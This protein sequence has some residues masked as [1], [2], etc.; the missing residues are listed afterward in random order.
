M[1]LVE[2]FVRRD[3]LTEIRTE[4]CEY[5]V[6]ILKM[7][8]GEDMV[9]EGAKRYLPPSVDAQGNPLPFDIGKAWGELDMKYN[10]AARE[11]RDSM[12]GHPAR[13]VYGSLQRF[14]AEVKRML[15]NG[16]PKKKPEPKKVAP[17]RSHH[18]PKPVPVPAQIEA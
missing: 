4:V 12:T 9:R 17:K 11:D 6:P 16:R 5:E 14:S 13:Q 10:H 1:Y 3:A 2:A 15:P 18:K 8:H 7:L